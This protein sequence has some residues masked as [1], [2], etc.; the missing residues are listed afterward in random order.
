[1]PYKR[2][3]T[4]KG[5]IEW[6]KYAYDEYYDCVICPEYQILKYA[7][8]NKDGYREY[9][10][11]TGICRSY[12]SRARCTVSKNCYKTVASHIWKDY[13]K[14]AK[15]VR[16]SPIGKET[17]EKRGKT[18]ER[19]FADGKKKYAMQYTPYRGLAHVSNW[20]K[21]K[22]ATMNLKKLAM[23]RWKDGLSTSPACLN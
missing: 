14:Q 8:T 17:Y 6:Y 21:L 16:H 13:I 19:V 10:S 18:I 15:D 1:M 9:K 23:W 2:P 20:V 5:N 11:D 3:M 12:T 22:Y 7:T 4:K